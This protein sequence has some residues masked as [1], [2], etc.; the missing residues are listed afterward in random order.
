ME[1]GNML[2]GLIPSNKSF[3][4][5]YNEAAKKVKFNDHIDVIPDKILPTQSKISTSV[6]R[7]IQQVITVEYNEKSLSKA[8]QIK[9]KRA[10]KA[11]QAAR[12]PSMQDF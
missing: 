4:E 8:Q 11:F 5:E 10:Q 2:W 1:L 6:N 9:A 12:T 3:F 7:S